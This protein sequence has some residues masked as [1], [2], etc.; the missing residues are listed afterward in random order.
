MTTQT[1]AQIK[2]T[3]AAAPATIDA[4]T[5][6]AAPAAGSEWAAP[7]AGTAP[8]AGAGGLVVTEGATVSSVASGIGS[9]IST[10]VPYYAA[11][12]IGG[13]ILTAAHPKEMSTTTVSGYMHT[14]GKSLQQ[15]LNVERTWGQALG[16]E[17]DDSTT[18]N[19]LHDI[20]NPLGYAERQ[21]GT[22]ICTEL[23]RQGLMSD[24]IY[25][26]DQRFGAKQDAAVIAGYHIWGIP[27]ASV[28]RKSRVVTMLIAPLAIA[29]AEDMAGKPNRLGAFLNKIGIPIC[30]FIGSRA[31]EVAHG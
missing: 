9:G 20:I 19:I 1:P 11:A 21:A 28:M 24:E 31:L 18:I 23:H 5:S 26:A 25:E 2:S 27:L 17:D 7:A 3:Y 29:W 12:R 13:N 14:L 16:L 4:G 22:V 6:W 8:T 10:A 15:P 30:R